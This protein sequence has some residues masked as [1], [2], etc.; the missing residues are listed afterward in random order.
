MPVPDD[1]G[2]GIQIAS[3]IDAPDAGKLAKDIA[4]ALAQRGV[5]RFASA[6]ARGATITTPVEGMLAW[7]RDV[8]LLTLWD[9]SAWTV[10]ATGAKSWTTVGLTSG[11]EHNGNDNGTFQ[12]RLVNLFGE[13][14]IM[15]RGA[16]SKDAYGIPWLV[17]GS[18][19]LT[20][21]P[22]PVAYRP[23]TKRTITVPCSDVNSVRITLKADIQTDGHIRLWGTQA[24]SRP[25][26]VS[27]NGCFASL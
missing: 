8:D 27:F 7:L 22:L 21:S 24:D 19:T 6:S 10:V 18:W 16:I 15:F 3:L 13:D 23:S 4:N 9:G 14:S 17:P 11:W 25:P 1:Y 2:Q 12:Y 5:M 20:A 26:W